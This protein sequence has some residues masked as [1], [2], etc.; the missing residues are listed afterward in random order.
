MYSTLLCENLLI[1]HVECVQKYSAIFLNDFFLPGFSLVM[2]TL[3]MLD[4]VKKFAS[5][6]FSVVVSADTEYLQNIRVS[7]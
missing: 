3:A 2:R 7:N 6:I 4:F 5:T 1:Y